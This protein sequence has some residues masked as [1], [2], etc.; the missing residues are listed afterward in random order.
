MALCVVVMLST[1][2]QQSPANHDALWLHVTIARQSRCIMAARDNSL[3][4][5]MPYRCTSQLPANHDTLICMRDVTAP[6]WSNF[7][8]HRLL[9]LS[10]IRTIELEIVLIKYSL[11]ILISYLT[12]VMKIIFTLAESRGKSTNRK[13]IWQPCLK[14]AL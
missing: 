3:P 4:I 13:T 6:P 11:E 10:R 1:A 7:I 8:G 14:H 5:T 9:W 2:S 12:H